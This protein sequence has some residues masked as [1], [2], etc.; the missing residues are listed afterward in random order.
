MLGFVR[1]ELKNGFRKIS[2]RSNGIDETPLGYF[3]DATAH[4]RAGRNGRDR[5]RLCSLPN[6]LVHLQSVFVAFGVGCLA[7]DP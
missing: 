1:R 3:F 4:N 2:G 5:M 6:N 7:A